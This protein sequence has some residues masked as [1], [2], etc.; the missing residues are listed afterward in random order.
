MKV[1]ANPNSSPIEVVS[2]LNYIVIIL[3]SGV[4]LPVGW[5]SSGVAVL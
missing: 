3:M 1:K 4:F 5:R 2:P